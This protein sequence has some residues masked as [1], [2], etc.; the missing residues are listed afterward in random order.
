MEG[1]I[2]AVEKKF[3]F[4][5]LIIASCLVLVGTGIVFTITVT[6]YAMG[7]SFEWAEELLRYL[8][9]CAALIGSGPMVFE[10]S[11]ICMDFFSN[12]IKNPTI[13]FYHAILNAVSIAVCSILLF[14][15]GFKLTLSTDMRT[16][17][18]IFDLGTV[19][20][21]I[22]LSMAVIFIYSLLKLALVIA[23]GTQSVTKDS[24]EVKGGEF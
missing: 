3:S 20:A 12:K 22:P 23:D 1:K 7:V 21:M 15:W 5:L 2:R 8:I 6:R 17:S 18:M 4:I 13:K 24:T 14:A 9:L 11:H 16:Y 10:D 19:Y